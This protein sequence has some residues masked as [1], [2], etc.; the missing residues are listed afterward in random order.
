MKRW[1]QALRALIH[2]ARFAAGVVFILAFGIAAN[3]AVFSIVDGV[4]L[5]PLPYPDPNRL[6]TVME[7]LWSTNIAGCR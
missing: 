7:R 1:R 3:T 6:V 5:K 2:R 4:L